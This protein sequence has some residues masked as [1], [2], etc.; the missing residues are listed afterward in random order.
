[1]VDTLPLPNILSGILAGKNYV[2]SVN[3]TVFF[4][5]KNIASEQ[6]VVYPQPGKQN[7]IQ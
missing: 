7:G 2:L 5:R 3:V 6:A 1:M 4:Y